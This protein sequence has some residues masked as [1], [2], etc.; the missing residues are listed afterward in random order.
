[1]SSLGAPRLWFLFQGVH[2]AG[3]GAA[4]RSGDGDLLAGQLQLPHRG[5]VPPHDLPQDR[6]TL[7]PRRAA[8]AALLLFRAGGVAAKHFFFL[9]IVGNEKEGV[10]GR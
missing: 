1:M 5:R 6:R 3:A 8:H 10:L 7:Q 4:P 2:G 9:N